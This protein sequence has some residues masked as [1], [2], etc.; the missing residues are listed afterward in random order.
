MYKFLLTK[1]NRFFY[2]FLTKKK[3]SEPTIG[4]TKDRPL[5]LVDAFQG[6]VM[7]DH[8]EMIAQWKLVATA[9]YDDATHDPMDEPH[10][11]NSKWDRSFQYYT[12]ARL[13]TT[14]MRCNGVA[15]ALHE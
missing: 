4:L 6:R 12:S 14:C 11:I 9:H 7:G 15:R 1:N 13:Y 3:K 2:R 5:P 10:L 8:S